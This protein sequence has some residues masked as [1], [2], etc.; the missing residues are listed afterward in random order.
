MKARTLINQQFAIVYDGETVEDPSP[1]WFEAEYWDRAGRLSAVAPGRGS[2]LFIDAPFGQVV[3]RRYLR[4]GWPARFSRDRYFFTGY[5]RS[6]PFREFQLL[7]ELT[8][9]ELP[10]PLPVAGLCQR[11]GIFCTGALLTGTITGALPLAAC[12]DEG[13]PG[14]AWRKVGACIARFHAAGVVHADLNARN[15]LLRPD[16]NDVYLVD[17]DRGR[18]RPGRP[19]DGRAALARLQRSLAKFLPSNASPGIDAGWSRLLEGYHA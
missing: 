15:I 18:Y 3:L 17:F 8:R 2:A 19:V 10:V 5:R 9:L 7:A 11:S 4:G 6:R 13:L 14:D 12:L 16:S 1:E